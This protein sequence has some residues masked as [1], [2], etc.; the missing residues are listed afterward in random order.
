MKRVYI[1]TLSYKH[2]WHVHIK[3]QSQEDNDG[4]IGVQLKPYKLPSRENCR[5]RQSDSTVHTNTDLRI[6]KP[7]HHT[8][9]KAVIAKIRL[10][11]FHLLYEDALLYRWVSI[12]EEESATC[13]KGQMPF[14]Y[15][16]SGQMPARTGR[17][18]S[19]MP[20]YRGSPG[21]RLKRTKNRPGSST[22]SSTRHIVS[23]IYDWYLSF[24]SNF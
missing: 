12:D 7:V 14:F 10:I 15:V 11:C 13:S 2:I 18:H 4:I 16:L 5:R 20:C 23:Y 21:S 8:T 6:C 3:S 9:A 24:R 17:N 19:E 1:L 22:F